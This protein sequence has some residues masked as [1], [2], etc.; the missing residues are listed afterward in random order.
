MAALGYHHIGMN[1]E[2]VLWLEL[3]MRPLLADTSV[4]EALAD[5]AWHLFV[6]SLYQCE[7]PDR[8]QALRQQR[9]ASGRSLSP[10]IGLK[11][12]LLDA[13]MALGAGQA[14]IGRAALVLAEPW[15]DPR[16]PR[17]AG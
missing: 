3:A 12:A 16:A 6:Q 17:S 15:L 7:A 8:A 14:E 11:L 2:R 5:E 10:G 13:Q 9:F 1:L 4:S